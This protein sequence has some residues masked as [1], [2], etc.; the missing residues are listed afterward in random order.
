MH[1]QP[2]IV[3]SWLSALLAV[4]VLVMPCANVSPAWGADGSLVIAALHLLERTYVDPI[5]PV[6]LLN[7]A[8][9]TLRQATNEGAGVLP[10]IAPG[11]P[12]ARADAQ[13]VSEFVRA[14][15]VSTLPEAQLA[16]AAT[17]GMLLSLHD[18]HTYYLDPVALRESQR[19]LLG[20]P[21]FSGIG[22]TIAS[23]KDAAGI[24]WVFV[25]NVFP[26]SPAARAG[27][28]R[29][30]RLVS[31]DGQS[32]RNATALDAS[33]LLRGPAGTTVSVTV[34][35]RTQTLHVSVAR[36]PIKV[37]PVETSFIAPGVAYITLFEFA[38]GAGQQLREEL[39]RLRARSPIRGVILD[40]RGDAGGLVVEA[41]SVGGLFLPPHTV[42]ARIHERDLVASAIETSGP[43]LFPQTPLV[44]L[45]D[46]GSASASEILAGAFKDYGRATIVGVKTA[47]A[48]GGSVLVRLPE[49]GMSVTV[50]RIVTPKSQRV[51]AVGIAPDVTVALT[52]ADMERGQDTQLQAALHA[53]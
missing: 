15:Q 23:R 50:E 47:G 9:A 20:Q 1:H 2:G 38:R 33:T 24:S 39:Q 30:D 44:V 11:T 28:K 26:G 18:S 4:A 45:V 27:I 43:P 14:A 46:D 37:V 53:L 8:I 35:R 6:P 48:L 22:V 16:Y 3:R 41:A 40:L 34:Q 36:A 42:L 31:V 17:E 29:F 19:Q 12:D 10:D 5:Q 25:E 21:S 7:A 51:E 32:L 49:G 52:V 13:F